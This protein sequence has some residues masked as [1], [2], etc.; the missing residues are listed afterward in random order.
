M[1][2]LPNS[3]QTWAVMF[4]RDPIN[5]ELLQAEGTHRI[6]FGRPSA[7]PGFPRCAADHRALLR[8]GPD[9]EGATTG[10]GNLAAIW[11]QHA[12]L[13]ATKVAASRPPA[14]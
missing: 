2:L 8:R 7:K 9:A 4:C 13:D 11:A 10:T 12:E 1:S 3:P 14:E 6:N 5:L